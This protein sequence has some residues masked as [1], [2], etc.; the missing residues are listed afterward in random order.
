MKPSILLDSGAF[1]ILKGGTGIDVYTY[2]DFLY[3]WKDYFVGYFVLDIIN[4][5]ELTWI[6]QKIMEDL[7]VKQK[8]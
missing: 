1:S 3:K 5:G 7:K 8:K 2:I 4:N 6:N